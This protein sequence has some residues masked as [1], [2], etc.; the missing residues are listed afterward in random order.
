M[1]LYVISSNN[2]ISNFCGLS[3]FC[4]RKVLMIGEKS[5]NLRDIVVLQH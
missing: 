5:L 3:Y 4:S 2:K 1:K